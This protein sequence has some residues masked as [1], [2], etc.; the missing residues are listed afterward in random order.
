MSSSSS[1][2]AHTATERVSKFLIE[3]CSSSSEV[4]TNFAYANKLLQHFRNSLATQ[5]DAIDNLELMST[6]LLAR[7]LITE[8]ATIS[9]LLKEDYEGITRE[10]SSRQT[11]NG[12]QPLLQAGLAELYI[13]RHLPQHHG[14]VTIVEATE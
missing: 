1:A 10:I 5:P 2:D 3:L 13:S 9:N 8:I 6:W 7:K 11:V 4:A 14:D 12:G